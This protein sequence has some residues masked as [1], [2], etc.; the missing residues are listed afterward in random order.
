MFTTSKLVVSL[1]VSMNLDTDRISQAI[2][3]WQGQRRL[4][5]SESLGTKNGK[6]SKLAIGGQLDK[7]ESPTCAVSAFVQYAESEVGTVDRMSAKAGKL[8]LEVKLTTIPATLSGQDV[9]A[10]LA[11]FAKPEA[12]PEAEVKPV[13][14]SRK[15]RKGAKPEAEK[16]PAIA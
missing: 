16:V 14:S 3:A 8:G 13:K 9:G 4:V 2:G 6:K 10:W 7:Y 5:S 11:K 1:L 15:S 12:K